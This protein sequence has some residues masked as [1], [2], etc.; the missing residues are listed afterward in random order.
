MYYFIIIF[1]Q[2]TVADRY[3]T[4]LNKW[5]DDTDRLVFLY[6]CLYLNE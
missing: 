2:A 6:Y 1:P 4:K 5:D 3:G